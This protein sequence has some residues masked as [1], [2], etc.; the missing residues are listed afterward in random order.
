LAPTCRARLLSRCLLIELWPLKP[1]E[2]V[3]EVN[4][5]DQGLIDAFKTLRRKLLRWANDNAS[6]LKNAEPL[7]PAGFTTRPRSN[8]KLLL[9]IAELGGAAWAEQARAAL[10]KLL[11]EKREPSWLELLLQELWMV[12]VTE[13][14]KNIKSATLVKR[15][16]ADP[17]SE[18][19][20]YSHGGGHGHRVTEREVAWL[21]RKLHIRP[22]PI[23]K[24]RVR[25]YHLAD[26][27]EK[28]VFQHF[29][30]RDPLIRSPKAQP[31]KRTPKKTKKSRRRKKA[32][33]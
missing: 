3:A 16:T 22:H 28:E 5:F 12:F 19:C 7:L 14:G 25:G 29:L 4:P 1:G 9:A 26:F 24:T 32:S 23:G 30:G 10:D 11:R 21:L 17:T 33:G 31:K 8:A 13:S 27:L 6:T 15:L 2:T 20:E 18:W